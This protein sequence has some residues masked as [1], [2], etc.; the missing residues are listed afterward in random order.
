M[1]GVKRVGRRG[2]NERLASR[3]DPRLIER[4]GEGGLSLNKLLPEIR[5]VHMVG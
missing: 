5:P 2:M 3:R 4:K 1:N